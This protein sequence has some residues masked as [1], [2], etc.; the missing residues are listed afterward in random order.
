MCVERLPLITPA[1]SN[2]EERYEELQQRLEYEHSSLSDY[3]LS[4]AE[5][6]NK[7]EQLKQ[8][9]DNEELRKEVAQLDSQYQVNVWRTIKL[10]NMEILSPMSWEVN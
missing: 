10:C 7:R 4:K 6:M 3:E 9:E 1:K 2:L 8:D 5:I